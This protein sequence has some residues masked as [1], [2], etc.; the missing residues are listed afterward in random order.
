MGPLD[1]LAPEPAPR[2]GRPP[3]RNAYVELHNLVAAAASVAEFGPADLR[4]ISERHGVDLRQRFL[5]ERTAL[6]ERLL[7]DAL[8]GGRL[9][10]DGRAELAHVARTL[11][12]S[13]DEVRPVHRRAFGLVVTAAVEDDRLTDEERVLLLTLQHAFGLDPTLADGAYDVLARERLVLAVARAL[14]DGECSPEEAEQVDGVCRDLSVEVPEAVRE[15]LR[16]AA[17]R[18]E[19]DHAEMPTAPVGIRLLPGEVGHYAV[20]RACWRTVNG[21]VLE[22]VLG[23]Y[24]ERVRRGQTETLRVP[25]VALGGR[26]DVGQVVLTSK[27][28]VLLPQQGLPDD[29]ALVS[30]LQT[31]RF[32]NGVVIRTR[33]DRRVFLDLGDE[34]DALYAL[35]YRAMHTGRSASSAGAEPGGRAPSRAGARGGDQSA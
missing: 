14:A 24:R 23:P 29:Y 21:S 20:R 19:A 33:G 7:D 17:E 2:W 15:R 1:L 10:A 31:L 3:E 27:R 35:L 32:S 13:A 16:A 25:E 28:L 22:R 5:A 18:W 8:A 30:L 12:L 26:T 4:R 11:A 34:G 6:Y 9:G